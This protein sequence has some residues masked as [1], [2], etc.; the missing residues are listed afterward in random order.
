MEIAELELR[1]KQIWVLYKQSKDRMFV[2]YLNDSFFFHSLRFLSLTF[3]SSFLFPLVFRSFKSNF[4]FVRQSR[5]RVD[6]G[7]LMRG[8]FMQHKQE[9]NQRKV[10]WAPLVV[11][12][13]VFFICLKKKEKKVVV[14][15]AFWKQNENASFIRICFVLFALQLF[16]SLF[17]FPLKLLLPC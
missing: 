8:F 16:Y 9:R 3:S 6:I 7:F 5:E 2:C 1:S 12:K 14:F 11:P 17:L 13:V 10:I 4:Y 15:Y